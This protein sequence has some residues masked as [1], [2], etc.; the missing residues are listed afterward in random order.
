MQL[1][2]H[3]W[4]DLEYFT[5]LNEGF[6]L[7]SGKEQKEIAGFFARHFP[8]ELAENIS[9]Q[10]EVNFQAIKELKRKFWPDVFKKID[11]IYYGSDNC[12]YLIPYVHEVKKALE[13]FGEFN[14][15][16]PPHK[17]RTFTLVTPY[18]GNK[19]LD[20]LEKT[21]AYLHENPQK[22]PV[23][24][25]VNDLGVLRLITQKY[26]S[27]KI[28][29][30]RLIHKVL[31]T[32]L[33]DTYG[34]EVHPSGELI[35]NKTAQEIEAMKQEIVKWQ[36]KFYASSEWSLPIYRQFLKKHSIGRITVDYM[37]KRE[38]LY[39]NYEDIGVDLYYPWALVFTGRLCDTSSVENPARGYYAIDDVCPRTCQRVDVFYKVKTIGYH[40]IQRGN[41]AYRSECN[42]DYVSKDWLENKNNRIIFSPFIP[43]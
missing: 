6:L 20:M 23:E 32:P 42:L 41:S 24:V 37:E 9:P 39:K 30:G 13:K 1:Y 29:F 16:F 3:L 26:T 12:E 18:V 25:V 17:V 22:F 43:V 7:P 38:D 33:I 35:R 21:L 19:M 2:L 28:T 27:L 4:T 34:Y 36:L 15:K 14:K 31:K 5:L 8:G 10:Y 40:L 11:G